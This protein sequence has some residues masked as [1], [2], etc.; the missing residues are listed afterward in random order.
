VEKVLFENNKV[1][2]ATLEVEIWG[3]GQKVLWDSMLTN[4]C[5]QLWAPNCCREAPVRGSWSRLTG[6]K[7]RPYLKNNK[8]KKSW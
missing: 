4:D 2:S 7:V 8:S 5:V 6:H 3:Q 1:F